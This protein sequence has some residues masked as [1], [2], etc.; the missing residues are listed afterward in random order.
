MVL[1]DISS[2]V[3]LSICMGVACCGWPISSRVALVG[4]PDLRWETFP[5]LL[6]LLPME[7]HFHNVGEFEDFPIKFSGVVKIVRS[8]EKIS[9]YATSS[10]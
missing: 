6:P 2:T 1:F 7:L 3:E 10:M 9:S 4:S 5:P 8:K